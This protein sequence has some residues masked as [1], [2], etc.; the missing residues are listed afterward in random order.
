MPTDK[1][2]NRFDLY[3]SKVRSSLGP[4]ALA[5]TYRQPISSHLLT[6]E[7]ALEATEIKKMVANKFTSNKDFVSSKKIKPQDQSSELEW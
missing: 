7:K 5:R 2:V 1:P 6:G 3:E 4:G